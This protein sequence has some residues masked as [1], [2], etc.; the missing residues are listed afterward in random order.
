MID[1]RLR[2]T[3][4][5]RFNRFSDRWENCLAET[6]EQ[7]IHLPGEHETVRFHVAKDKTISLTL[8]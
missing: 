3:G 8:K 4:V 2:I 6:A 7:I 1:D 5:K